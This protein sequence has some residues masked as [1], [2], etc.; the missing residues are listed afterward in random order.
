[1]TLENDDGLVD[2]PSKHSLDETVEKFKAIL[3]AKG[4]T[5]FALIDHTAAAAV[6]FACR[7]S[8]KYRCDRSV[9]CQRSGMTKAKQNLIN[10]VRFNRASHCT[11]KRFRQGF[12]NTDN[13]GTATFM[14]N[15]FTDILS[16]WHSFFSL[17]GQ[18]AVTLMGLVFVAASLGASLAKA[19]STA[20]GIRAFVNP[21]IIHFS[22]VMVLASLTLIP[23]QGFNSLGSLL[24]LTGVAGLL[25]AGVVIV[26]L[27]K[28]HRRHTPVALVD[29]FWSG[30]LP[31]LGYLLILTAALGLL[32]RVPFALNGLAL[33]V[34][35]FLLLGIRNAWNLL[36]W[37]AQHQ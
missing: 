10:A 31:A 9:S 1:M 20:S 11:L 18:A 25:Y 3:N 16:E 13:L 17:T 23:T 7:A 2:L 27:R 35:V 14:G 21:T 37:I 12:K 36:L 32:M 33:A 22:A 4:I 30:C 5:L 26:Q 6:Q 34:I 8:Q 28:H 15:S 24:C 29:W 19:G